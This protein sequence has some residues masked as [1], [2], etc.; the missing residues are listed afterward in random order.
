MLS[1]RRACCALVLS[2]LA[3]PLCS[4]NAS[5]EDDSRTQAAAA[6]QV[7]SQQAL[8]SQPAKD[9]E[10]ATS[11]IVLS[12]TVSDPSG[13]KVTHAKV[14]VQSAALRRDIATDADGRFSVALQP[15]AYDVIIVSPDFE[16]YLTNVTLS[17]KDT[18]A[19]IDAKL[20]IATQAE[21]ITVP[22]AEEA[23]G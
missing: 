17:S 14:H 6:T 5:A 3:A 20:V 11:G 12:G 8:L 21:E 16:P 15:G 13:A 23:S 1:L 10:P 9:A 7:V 4:L 18:H 22:A 19:N 2:C